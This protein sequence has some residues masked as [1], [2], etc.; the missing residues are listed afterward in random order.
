VKFRGPAQMKK[1]AAIIG[2]VALASMA[3]ACGGGASATK[4]TGKSKS[5]AAAKPKTLGL[6]DTVDINDGDGNK[7]TVTVNKVTYRTKGCG[8]DFDGMEDP[9]KGDAYILIDT[10]YQS[11]SG[12]ASYNP[13]DWSV[14]DTKGDE[15]TDP[16]LTDCKPALSSSN[17]LVGKRHGIVVIEVK[18]GV[19]HGTA[20]YQ[21]P[22]GETS[23]SWTF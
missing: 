10:T 21:T 19:E 8:D 2:V 7:W 9:K 5:T 22:L 12:K 3:I 20:V 17:S 6:G 16:G 11:V 13:L 14:V 18:K 15:S 23:T 4:A 1:Y